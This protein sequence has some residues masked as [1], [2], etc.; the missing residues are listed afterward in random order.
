MGTKLNRS[1]GNKHLGLAWFWIWLSS[2]SLVVG[3]L[4]TYFKQNHFCVVLG[5]FVY[6]FFFFFHVDSAMNVGG[7][8]LGFGRGCKCMTAP[9]PLASKLS[10]PLSIYLSSGGGC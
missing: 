6:F 4:E 2:I 3:K 5:V 10:S 8:V 9:F 1:S 7:N